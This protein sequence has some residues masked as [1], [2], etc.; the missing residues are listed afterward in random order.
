[1]G[2]HGKLEIHKWAEKILDSLPA[3]PPPALCTGADVLALGI[4]EG[5]LVGRILRSLDEEIEAREVPDR[6]TAL[7]LLGRLVRERYS[8][9]H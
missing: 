7:A 2:S 8:D 4:A 1:M 5:P 9:N 6:Q 3:E